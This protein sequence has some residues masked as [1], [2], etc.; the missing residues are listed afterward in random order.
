MANPVEFYAS[1]INPR[2]GAR[3]GWSKD[4]S[5]KVYG[6]CGGDYDTRACGGVWKHGRTDSENLL[7]DAAA[8]KPAEKKDLKIE[9][10]PDPRHEPEP[11]PAAKPLGSLITEFFSS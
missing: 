6:R 10:A 2:C 8:K 4:A 5:G 3:I 1:C 9:P 7:R 11:R